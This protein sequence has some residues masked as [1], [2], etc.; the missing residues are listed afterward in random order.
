MARM[1]PTTDRVPEGVYRKY[2]PRGSFFDGK[3][4]DVIGRDRKR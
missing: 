4:W 1:W 3:R 2:N